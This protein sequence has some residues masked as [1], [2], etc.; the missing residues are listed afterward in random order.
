VKKHESEKLAKLFQ[1]MRSKHVSSQRLY[2]QLTKVRTPRI[3]GVRT[4]ENGHL[5]PLEI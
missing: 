1:A 4:G 3:M 2:G 5:L